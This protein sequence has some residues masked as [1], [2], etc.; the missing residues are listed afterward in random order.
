MGFIIWY[1]VVVAVAVDVEGVMAVD[2]A[3]VV[4][5]ASTFKASAK[6]LLVLLLLLLLTECN[7]TVEEEE[8]EGRET[9]AVCGLVRSFVAELFL[10]S[11]EVFTTL[12]Y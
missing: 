11:E 9:I 8:E 3:L 2:C 7:L 10:L 12:T 1:F 4:F 6:M 5:L